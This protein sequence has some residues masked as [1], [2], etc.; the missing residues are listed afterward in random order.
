MSHKVVLKSPDSK[1]VE[2]DFN[3][4][5]HFNSHVLVGVKS[6]KFGFPPDFTATDQ[7]SKSSPPGGGGHAAD[8]V[9]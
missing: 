2:G 3:L 7:Q 9:I 8:L 4:L 1:D 5:K 6:V